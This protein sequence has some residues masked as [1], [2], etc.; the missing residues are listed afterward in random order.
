MEFVKN[1]RK[2]E[3][4]MF[5]MSKIRHNTWYRSR[6]FKDYFF[7][8]HGKHEDDYEF[9]VIYTTLELLQKTSKSLFGTR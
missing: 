9:P 3:R 8:T 4:M 6:H 1:Q 2:L 5:E 7:W